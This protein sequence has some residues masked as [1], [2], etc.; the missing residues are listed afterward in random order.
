MNRVN[1]YLLKEK[2]DRENTQKKY[3]KK[4]KENISNLCKKE[5]EDYAKNLKMKKI[6]NQIVVEDNYRYTQIKNK[7][8]ENEK[9]KNQ[10]RTYNG[11]FFKGVENNKCD[12]C[13]RAYPKNVLSQLYYT[14][15]AQQKK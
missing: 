11:L 8:N 13:N 10:Q 15:D 1:S 7:N 4:E 3:K 9:I 14:Y 5:I 2:K 6:Q 12:Q